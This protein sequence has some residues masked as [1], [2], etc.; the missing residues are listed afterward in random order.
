MEQ[1]RSR[2]SEREGFVQEINRVPAVSVNDDRFWRRS[3]ENDAANRI[4]VVL[5]K[6]AGEQAVGGLSIDK[7]IDTREEGTSLLGGTLENCRNQTTFVA[8]H[9]TRVDILTLGSKF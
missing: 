7:R 6:E 8:I 5:V 3:C 9:V 2:D 1:S 4:S